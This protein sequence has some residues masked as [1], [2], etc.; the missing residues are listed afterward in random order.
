ML[1]FS[2]NSCDWNA[3]SEKHVDKWNKD[4]GGENKKDEIMGAKRDKER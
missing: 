3:V 1:I 4:L 2:G